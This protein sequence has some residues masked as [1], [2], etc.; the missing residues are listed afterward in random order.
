MI[1][2]PNHRKKFYGHRKSER[3]FSPL[4]TRRGK[5]GVATGRVGMAAENKRAAVITKLEMVTEKTTK[6][7]QEG[8]GMSILVIYDIPLE[9]E[10]TDNLH[11]EIGN[12]TDEEQI[13]I[14]GEIQPDGNQ[15]LRQKRKLVFSTEEKQLI[16]TNQMLSDESINL[17]QN[18]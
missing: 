6:V 9:M 4:P 7:S 1:Q 2:D 12:I 18:L 8:V 14:T 3:I 5:A 16:K 17:A 11:L 13:Q 15:V 10:I